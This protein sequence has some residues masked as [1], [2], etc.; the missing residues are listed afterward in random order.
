MDIPTR[1]SKPRT[2]ARPPLFSLFPFFQL[3]SALSER[4]ARKRTRAGRRRGAGQLLSRRTTNQGCAVVSAGS[5]AH[6]RCRAA[7]P[8]SGECYC[9]SPEG[10]LPAP[11]G[12]ARAATSVYAATVASDTPWG[13]HS[14][15]PAGGVICEK[16]ANEIVNLVQT[17]GGFSNVVVCIPVG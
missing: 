2:P 12:L 9:V 16:Y 17:K 10:R 1:S 7:T 4:A 13:D 8:A 11:A 6:C 5:I 14:A 15:L 3:F